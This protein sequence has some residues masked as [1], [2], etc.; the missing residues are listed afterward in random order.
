MPRAIQHVPILYPSRAAVNRNCGY[1]GTAV[2]VA[3]AAAMPNHL[4]LVRRAAEG[5]RTREKAVDAAREKL[6]ER[7]REAAR[8]GE[9]RSAIA[10]AAGVSRQWITR[11]LEVKR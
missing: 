9:S 7:I 10:R 5:L 6:H 8:A 4:E 2:A 11:L 3:N 1:G